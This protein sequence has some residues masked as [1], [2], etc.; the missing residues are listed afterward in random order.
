MKQHKIVFSGPVGAGKTTAIRS[1]SDID[2]VGT[3]ADASDEVKAM[4]SHTT[5]A[6]DYGII[7]LDNALKVHLYGT[8][9]QERFNFMWDILADGALGLILLIDAS[10][11]TAQDDLEYYL[12]AFTKLIDET[13]VCVGL[14][15]CDETQRM[16]LDEASAI[17][18]KLN[19]HGPVFEVDARDRKDMSILLKGLLFALDPGIEDAG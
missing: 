15:R 6:M 1:L 9:G 12:N 10:R 17:M 7:Y 4:K 18:R 3:E 19:R 13:A 11:A 8:P 2:V 14:T 16:N 5:V